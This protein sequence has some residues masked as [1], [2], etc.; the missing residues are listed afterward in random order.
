MSPTP[1]PEPSVPCP[2]VR[3]DPAGQRTRAAFE[4]A[5]CGKP[6]E[7]DSLDLTN[8]RCELGHVVWATPAE[9]QALGHGPSHTRIGVAV[10]V[11]IS[12]YSDAPLLVLWGRRRGSPGSFGAG[13][14]AFPGG[15]VKPG[16]SP[17][18]AAAREL[19]EETGLVVDPVEVHAL[20][21]WQ[22]FV[23][24]N[25]YERWICV[26]ATV[27]ISRDRID[28]VQLLEPTKCAGWE[29]REHPGSFGLPSPM[30]EP[31]Q[32]QIADGALDDLDAYP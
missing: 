14:W 27:R 30:F 19:A 10:V 23:H 18:E 13:T 21:H 22:S 12:R 16:E 1:P 31:S 6:A 3:A 11:T 25:T 17:E 7:R 26:I 28:D 2:C 8:L 20:P 32:C 29:W 9:L 24:P 15:E 5:R 4:L